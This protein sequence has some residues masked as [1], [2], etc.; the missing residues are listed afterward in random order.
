MRGD[1]EQPIKDDNT[2]LLN[3][4]TEHSARSA[5]R[6]GEGEVGVILLDRACEDTGKSLGFMRKKLGHPSSLA[7][8][9]IAPE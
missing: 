6:N 8:M 9:P 1:T 5:F 4:V 7:E 2:I 3:H